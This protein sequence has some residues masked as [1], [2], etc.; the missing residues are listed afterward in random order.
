MCFCVHHDRIGKSGLHP[1]DSSIQ[2]DSVLNPAIRLAPFITR[3]VPEPER[4]AGM[5]LLNAE[6][7]RDRTCPYELEG[8][9][10]SQLNH[11]EVVVIFVH[12][13]RRLDIDVCVLE[14]VPATPSPTLTHG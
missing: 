10:V 14:L 11:H 9:S 5:V 4:S 2:N 7:D 3:V 6:A 12:A 8:H 1:V 13:D